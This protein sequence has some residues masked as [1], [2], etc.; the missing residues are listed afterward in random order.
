M[1]AFDERL[2]F[3]AVLA[4]CLLA[5]ILSSALSKPPKLEV[6]TIKI[7]GEAG[8]FKAFIAPEKWG[9]SPVV[10]SSLLRGK[11]SFLFEE[12]E[13]A[14]VWLGP[15]QLL[16]VKA[17]GEDRGEIVILELKRGGSGLALLLEGLRAG[18][19]V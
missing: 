7:L 5:G 8:D 10:D 4:T 9:P 13:R 3:P 18:T 1:R 12:G 14:V 6:R 19:E 11:E 2:L 16:G 17:Y 15:Y